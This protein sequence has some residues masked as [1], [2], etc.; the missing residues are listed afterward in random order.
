MA[1]REAWFEGQLDLD[2]ERV[3][4]IDETAAA[5]NMVRRYGRAPCGQRCR[6]VPAAPQANRLRSNQISIAPRADP[7]VRAWAAFGR[8]PSPDAMIGASRH[9]KTFTNSGIQQV[10]FPAV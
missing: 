10:R 9:P 1:A 6:T 5:T 2:P 7:R 3:V 4:F 8:R